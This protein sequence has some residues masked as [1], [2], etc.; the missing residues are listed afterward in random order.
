M[1]QYSICEYEYEFD[2]TIVSQ[3]SLFLNQMV[4]RFG[5]MHE[6][7]SEGSFLNVS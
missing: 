6:S 3:P 1:R 5:S 7:L 2:D 4:L